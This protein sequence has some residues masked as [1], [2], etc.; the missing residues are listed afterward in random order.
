MASSGPRSPG[1]LGN[2]NIPTGLDWGDPSNAGASDDSYATRG[3]GMSGGF[4]NYLKATN[5]GFAI[6][7]GSTI[8]GIEVFVERK[9]SQADTVKDYR[10]RAVKGGAT[11]ST[12]KASATYWPTSDGSATYG[13]A[14]DLWGETWTADDINDAGFGAA[15][16]AV[17]DDAIAERTASVDHISITVHYTPAATNAKNML[18]MGVS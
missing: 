3:L 14:A 10:V 16:A 4:S 13:G 9:G 5:Y 8:N 6:P 11:G 18:M 12:D 2:E 17:N 7:A 1:T 15:L